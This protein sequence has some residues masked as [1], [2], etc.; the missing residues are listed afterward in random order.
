MPWRSL[1]L[2]ETDPQPSLWEALLPEQVRRLPAE[3]AR[4]D[5]Y[6]DDECFVAP[7][8]ALFDQRLG[9]PSVP[10]ESLLRLLYLKHRYQLGYESLCREVADS[11]SWRRFC[12]IGLDRPV[13]HPTTLVK[14]VRRAGP[15]TVG[16]LNSALLG[17]LREDKLL[18]VRKLRVDTTVVEAD[19][20]HPPTP[21]CWRRPSASWVGSSG[22]TRAVAR[23]PAPGSGTGRGRRGGGSSR[24]PGPCGGGPGRRQRR[25]IGSPPRSPPS[26]G[27]RSGRPSGS[28]TPP[29][30]RGVPGPPT[31]TLGGWSGGW[32]RRPR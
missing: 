16:Q 3:L 19:I 32:T 7:W 6:L 5:A 27:R 25:L 8:R 13:P 21:T 4:I 22:G 23:P 12:R 2:R 31:A 30:A 20:D 17:K 1:V 10:V 15:N 11:I 29:A 28:P 26:P 18:R 9:C 24:S 14:L